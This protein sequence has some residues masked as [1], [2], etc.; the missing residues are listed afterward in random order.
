M[1]E[2]HNSS[3]CF[4]KD[5]GNNLM[6]RLAR[7]KKTL[8]A[9][10]IVVFFILFFNILLSIAN[11]NIKEKS[12][13]DIYNSCN[14]IWAARGFYETKDKQNSLESITKAFDL[15][16]NGVEV[17]FYYDVNM[18]KFIVSHSKPKELKDG[19]FQ[20]TLKDGKLLTLEE[21]FKKTS[22]D[23]F[24]WLDYK[25]LD[26]LSS[27]ESISAIN[28]LKTIS[29][30]NNLKNRLYIEGSNPYK[31]SM[32]TKAGFYTIIGIHP[33]KSDA[34]FS[35]IVLKGY[36]I[37][38]GLFDISAI[39]MPY[40]SVKKNIYGSETKNIFDEIPIFLFHIPDIPKLL[41]KLL[42][43]NSIRVML[44]GRDKSVNRYNLTNCK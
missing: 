22:Q 26:R 18:D 12:F 14:K 16:A 38:Y 9:L 15:G 39:A 28:K 13:T 4:T 36:K 34:L 1:Y 21:L 40:G 44:V 2:A 24:F 29:K 3:R 43:D 35:S 7:Y 17:D 32:Y 41:S 11:K 5:K 42:K 23:K 19:T 10:T 20:Y 33:L 30:S 6:K 25:N 27:K 31:L 8:V 37:A